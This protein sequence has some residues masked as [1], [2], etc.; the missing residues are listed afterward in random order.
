MAEANNDA[1]TSQAE[2]SQGQPANNEGA[3]SENKSVDSAE[4]ARRDQQS[5]KDKANSELDEFRSELS[6]LKEAHAIQERDKY[7]ATVVS[8]KEKFPNVEADDPMFKYA[9]S[10]EE[11]E[12]IAKTLQDKYSTMQQKALSDVQSEPEYLTDE[13][14]A[15]NE[16]KLEKEVQESGTSKFGSWFDNISRRKR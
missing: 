10:K 16:Q 14:I 1:N 8:D 9:Y 4:Q 3:S 12:E 15:E 6:T 2:D 7:V 11:V 5:K 13:Q